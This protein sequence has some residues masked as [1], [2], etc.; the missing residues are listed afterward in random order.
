[1]TGISQ[2]KVLTVEEV[3]TIYVMAGEQSL[4]TPPFVMSLCFYGRKEHKYVPKF[5]HST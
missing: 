2:I 4:I 5:S 3:G 1:M